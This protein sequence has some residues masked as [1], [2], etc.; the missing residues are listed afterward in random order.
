MQGRRT[1]SG[2]CS[3]ARVNSA[4]IEGMVAEKSSVC[5]VGGTEPRIASSCEAKPISKS[6]SASSHTTYSTRESESWASTSTCCSR[7]GVPTRM[8]GLRASTSNCES[9]ESPPT[10]SAMPSAG[11]TKCDSSRQNLC[12]CSAS[13]R[14]GESTSPRSPTTV[15]CAPSFSSMGIAKAAVLPEPV[16]AMATTSRPAN[17]N[18]IVR[19]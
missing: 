3:L 11:V 14:V 12:V 19:R 4:S 1:S 18:G 6:R 16:R 13:S 7:P 17:I 8:S 15:E 2:S 9:T 10:R 5:R